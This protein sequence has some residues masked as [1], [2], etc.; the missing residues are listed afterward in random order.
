MPGL[1]GP[2][3]GGFWLGGGPVGGGVV[4]GGAGDVVVG[5]GA[6]LVVVGRGLGLAGF[7]GVGLAD[8]D[9]DGVLEK[10][11]RTLGDGDDPWWCL[12]S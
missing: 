5:C 10:V 11:I 4:A 2:P 3:P 6:G 9:L 8:A 7:E 12:C 1:A